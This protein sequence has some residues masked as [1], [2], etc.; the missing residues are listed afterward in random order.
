M[1]SGTTIQR[2]GITYI[3]QVEGTSFTEKNKSNCV[4]P[5][6]ETRWITIKQALKRGLITSL[7]KQSDDLF[8][9]SQ[10]LSYND[11][12]IAEPSEVLAGKMIS[13]TDSVSTYYM[14]LDQL[15]AQVFFAHGLIYPAAYDS[16]GMA[17]DFSDS[18]SLAPN[19]LTL[20]L[21]PQVIPANHLQFRLML[22]PDEVQGA[23][24]FKSGLR[25]SQPLPISRILEV[26][27]CPEVKNIQRYL[28]GL[29]KPDVPIPSHL[30]CLGAKKAAVP[31]EVATVSTLGTKVSPS[32]KIAEG[33]RKFN[34][35][36][37]AL[38]F[39][40][41]ASRY[42]SEKTGSYADYPLSFFALAEAL[43]DMSLSV[44]ETTS[45]PML[46]LAILGLK[47]PEGLDEEA[48]FRLVVSGLTYIDKDA[49]RNCARELFVAH[50]KNERL[51]QAFNALFAKNDY[52]TAIR[53]L[54]GTSMPT[55]AA[56]LAVLFKFSNLNGDD[57]R[58]VKQWLHDDWSSAEKMEAALCALGAYYGYTALDAKETK[59]YSIHPQFR[60]LL[61]EM[62][63]IKF[64]L[65]TRF[66]RRLIEA[67]YQ[68]SFNGGSNRKGALS[69]YN[70]D[71]VRTVNGSP[72]RPNTSMKDTSF[73]IQDL[74]VRRY[75]IVS[76]WGR[77][78]G[79]L[80][81]LTR[82]FVDESSETGR[83]LMSSCFFYAESHELS[84][85][86]NAQVLRYRISVDRL[87]ELLTDGHVKV[88]ANILEATLA[89][90]SGDIKQ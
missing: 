80:R 88:S 67:V 37:G 2:E 17:N 38:A 55:S 25:L 70:S 26:Q 53:E 51:A 40:R 9:E 20:F 82:G 10:S 47:P 81:R 4:L 46:S 32:A 84:K 19:E 28:A 21:L 22:L 11:M 56:I 89:E 72:L 45:T 85:L 39:L 44:P 52:R 68:L 75:T 90:D 34:Q 73:L 54:Q 64:E 41:N 43:M 83:Y 79:L 6:G 8:C 57:R 18:Q 50:G 3:I 35:C 63:A 66:E 33:I 74:S 42:L 1:N 77:I 87:I 65:S 76:P 59:L 30:F 13:S 48:L 23:S 12:P 71:L 15:R 5:K 62:P 60:P 24:K 58:S 69:L 31:K 27:V 16:V 86:G 49:A 29:V 36:L 7:S 14:T 61:I 78:I